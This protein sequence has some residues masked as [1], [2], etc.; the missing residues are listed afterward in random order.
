V[1]AAISI[2]RLPGMCHYPDVKSGKRMPALFFL[3]AVLL[4][5]G[6]SAIWTAQREPEYHGRALGEWAALYQKSSRLH[7]PATQKQAVDAAH[8][9]RDQLVPY[10]VSLIKQQPPWWRTALIRGLSKSG[11]SDRI[12]GPLRAFLYSDPAWLGTTYFAML[13]PD[14]DSA[15]PELVS[16]LKQN[17]SPSV[18]SRVIYALCYIGPA[19]Q[20]RLAE[21]IADP[22]YPDRRGTAY[23]I[24]E[25]QKQGVIVDALVPSLIKNLAASDEK[26]ATATAYSLGEMAIKPDLVIPALTNCLRST[27]IYVRGAAMDALAKFGAG[28]RSAVPALVPG[29]DDLDPSVRKWATNALTHIEPDYFQ[30]AKNWTATPFDLMAP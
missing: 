22:A 20:A 17:R 18:S 19:G 27:D 26:V 3:L 10:A 30:P 1:D 8:Q 28:A 6:L 2:L 29:L 15:V 16:V 23:M 14:A 5:L 12:T 9:T 13:G 11:Y 21:I 7:D 4:A 24:E 25:L